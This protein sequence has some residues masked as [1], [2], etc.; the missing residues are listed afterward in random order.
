MHTQK[1]EEKMLHPETLSGA[2]VDEL[3]RSMEIL[4]ESKYK[5]QLFASK[6]F[7]KLVSSAFDPRADLPHALRKNIV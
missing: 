3:I 1:L 2:D 5:A 7:S 4:K 6:L